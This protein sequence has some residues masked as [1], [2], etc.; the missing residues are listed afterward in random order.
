[1]GQAETVHFGKG[2]RNGSTNECQNCT[3]QLVVQDGEE[4][5]DKFGREGFIEEYECIN[6]NEHGL[7][8]EVSKTGK[9]RY[10]GVCANHQ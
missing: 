2:A 7:Y 5:T 3:G 10:T 6:C 4:L 9:N 8:K 1:M